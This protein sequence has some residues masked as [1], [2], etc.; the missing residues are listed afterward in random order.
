[1]KIKRKIVTIAILS[2]SILFGVLTIQ[3]Q[4]VNETNETNTQSSQ[5]TTDTASNANLSNLGIRPHDFTG[6]RYGTTS[7]EVSVPE[8]TESVEVY[9][10]TQ[11]EK[12]TVSGTGNKKLEMGENKVEVVV[13]AEDGT[14]K[15]YTITIIR[16]AED[17][18]EKEETNNNITV[19]NGLDQLKIN[20]VELSPKFKTNV[21]EYTAKYI[22]EDIRLEIEAKPTDDSYIVEIVGNDNLQEGQNFITILVSEENEGN[23]ATYQIEVNKSLIDEEA[24][25]KE[26]KEKKKQQ[27]KFMISGAIVVV[28]VIIAASIIIIVHKKNKELEREFSG[29][30]YYDENEEEE[31]I[32]RALRGKRFQEELKREEEEDFERMPREKL[33][34]EFLNGY[35]SE[36]DTNFDF[37]DNRYQ[38]NRRVAKHKGKRFK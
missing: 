27:Q 18:E 8:D 4:A 22:G 15:T 38:D 6:F 9:A 21:Y 16:K 5:D 12:A 13:T 33:K 7:Y 10:S 3:N 14:K 25:A 23:I 1:M 2:I 11:A 17:G 37:G 24:V 35:T 26:E 34:E 30:T 19:G 20:D 31:E 28:A 32:P 36:F 29:N